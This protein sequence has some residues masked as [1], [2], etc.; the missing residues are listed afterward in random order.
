MPCSA[1]ARRP[2]SR[3]RMEDRAGAFQAMQHIG[4][5]AC[6]APDADV[7]ADAAPARGG[8]HEHAIALARHIRRPG[9]IAL[10]RRD[11]RIP[12]AD[13]RRARLQARARAI[14][15]FMRR[16]R[17]LA[18]EA[19][20]QHGDH[21]IRAIVAPLDV[22][23]AHIGLR[24][25]LFVHF[26]H[27]P[28]AR[29][30]RLRA[31][32]RDARL[33]TRFAHR[34]LAHVAVRRAIAPSGPGGPALFSLSAPGGGEGWGEVGVNIRTALARSADRGAGARRRRPRA[35]RS[36]AARSPAPD[37]RRCRPRPA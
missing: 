7:M 1:S 24:P 37:P 13:S 32:T 33:A 34:A 36:R 6:G 23:P 29:I 2:R 8:H 26:P 28:G 35:D 25:M 19:L 4:L 18:A 17:D 12:F 5:S 3:K 10:E 20:A 22:G 16:Q 21:E 9:V 11:L 15:R 30:A 27:A 14:D 31:W